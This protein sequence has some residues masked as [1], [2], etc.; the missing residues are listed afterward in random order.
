MT[1]AGNDRSAITGRITG[2]QHGWPFA[3]ATFDLAASG[4]VEDEWRLEGDALM[5]EHSAGT[6]RSFDGRWSAA[7]TDTVAFATRLLVR[8]PVDPA[9]FN[10]TVILLWNNVSLGFDLMAGESPEIYD[11]GFAFVGVSAQRNGVH[12]YAGD[13]SPGL[14]LW[15]PQRYGS[16]VVPSDGAAY[17]IFTQAGTAV[18]RD[19]PRS[20]PDPLGGLSVERVIALGA[21]QSANWLATYLNAVQPMTGAVDGF[22]LDIYFGNGSPL[23]PSTVTTS[24]VATPKDIPDAVTTMPPGS[25]L[26][27]DDLGV[28]IFVLNSESEATGYHPVRQ[29]DT[30]HFR[31]WEVA[32]HAHGSRH[33]G[34]DRL[35][36][37]WP[38]DLGTEESPM[39]TPVDANI[40]SM[41]PVRSAVLHHFQRWLTNGVTP[42]RQP[43]IIFDVGDDGR[44]LIRRDH[45]GLAQGGVRL[46]DVDVPTARHSGRGADG[47]LVLTG[48]TTPFSDETLRAL[49]P[50]REAYLDRYIAAAANAVNEGVLLPDDAARLI[51][52]AT[53]CCVGG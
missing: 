7:P 11:G 46:P 12:G 51:T 10:G 5:Y 32:G 25:H 35:P 50:T 28:P 19:R 8:R 29:S 4:Y 6:S 36:S 45:L 52:V 15:D 34:S 26:L 27:R 40:L 42:P 53:G 2:G 18:G 49:Y 47:T 37:N 14:T 3:G 33:R 44:P 43:P 22:I 9:R 24:R 13:A 41:E 21:S 38:R 20:S 30:D 48:S 1:K 23:D 39:G 16:L 17:D 31:F